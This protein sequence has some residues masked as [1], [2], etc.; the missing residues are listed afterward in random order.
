MNIKL[1]IFDIYIDTCVLI[2]VHKN[3]FLQH[4]QAEPG[5]KVSVSALMLAQMIRPHEGFVTISA[6]EVLHPSVH[7]LVARQLVTPEMKSKEI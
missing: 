4:L 5:P 2:L 6:H 7:P 1:Q 3:I